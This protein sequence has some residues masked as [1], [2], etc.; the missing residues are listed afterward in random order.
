MALY[1]HHDNQTLL[2]TI[3]HRNQ[4]FA[5]LDQ[6]YK[7]KLFK[8][9]IERVYQEIGRKQLTPADLGEYNKRTLRNIVLPQE[10]RILP[11]ESRVDPRLQMQPQPPPPPPS[12]VLAHE[13]GAISAA[14]FTQ[15]SRNNVKSNEQFAKYQEEYNTM[16]VKKEPKPLEFAEKEDTKIHNMHELVEKHKKEREQELL[17]HAETMKNTMV[18]QSQEPIQNALLQ[19][20]INELRTQVLSLQKEINVLHLFSSKTPTSW[21]VMNEKGGLLCASEMRKGVKGQTERVPE[22]VQNINITIDDVQNN[23]PHSFMPSPSPSHGQLI[24]PIQNINIE[25]DENP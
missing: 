20:Q 3:L 22:P 16:F 13:Y 15:E 14:S 23:V 19:D 7:T 5:N 21:A 8:T 1:I 2:W 10:T 24:E 12:P 6:Q 11:Q 17:M 4:A 25:F 18:I 9:N